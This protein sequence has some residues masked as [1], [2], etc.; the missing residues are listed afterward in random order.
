MGIWTL[1]L[2]F[3]AKISNVI[4]IGSNI[5]TH[6]NL[7]SRTMIWKKNNISP[8]LKTQTSYLLGIFIPHRSTSWQQLSQW[9]K[10]SIRWELGARSK[11]AIFFCTIS[12][13]MNCRDRSNTFLFTDLIRFVLMI[14]SHGISKIIDFILFPPQ[15]IAF[16]YRL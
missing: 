13:G 11:K 4:K 3:S 5:M 10:I 16:F 8:I 2:D 7:E 1:N 15:I 6:Y 14:W 9:W 12:V